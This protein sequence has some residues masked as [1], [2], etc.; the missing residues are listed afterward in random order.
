[1]QNSV[2]KVREA[3]F[4]RMTTAPV[5]PLIVKLAIPT[6]I[7]MLV[8]SIYNMA[9]TFFVAH[10]GQTEAEV[11]AA[12]GAVGVVFSLMAVIQALGFTLGMGSGSIISRALGVK[13][14]KRAETAASS[15]LAAALVLGGLLTVFGLIFIKPLVRFLGATETILP[16]AASYASYILYGAPIMCASFVLNNLL[17]SEGKALFSMV[18]LTLG[19]VLN[20]ALDPLLIFTAGLGISGAAIATIASQTVSFLVMLSFFIFKKSALRLSIRSVSL[21]LRL[22]SEIIRTGLPS[23]L[24]QGLASVANIFLSTQAGLYGGDHAVS[25][26]SIVGKIFMMLF[27]VGLGIGQGYQPVAGYN[28]SSKNYAR[29]KTA[30][31]FTL[32]VNTA[33]MTVFG[34]LAY[35]FAPQV[36]SLIIEDNSPGIVETGALALRFQALAMPLLA[37][38]VS[39]NMTF[40][41]IGR[42]LKAAL[43]STC[44]QGI[45]Y[46]PA[47]YFL[48]SFLGLLGVQCA[49][50]VADVCTFLVS[51][52]F[53]IGFYREISRK[54][55]TLS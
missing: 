37:T 12:S 38:N 28:Y 52:P 34:V 29:V 54:C 51:V 1:M 49:Q 7:S 25:G 24:R 4:V 32:L 53:A 13:D 45:F 40:Q 22:Y 35:I 27:C 15:A 42:K 19:G 14:S 50:C 23:F 11:A 39:C 46:L 44:R 33:V 18:G 30:F 6:V 5:R 43:L 10:I 26:M 41:T 16:Y 17:R 31:T 47:I 8:T 21:S 36:I 20:I 55:R 2:E 3:Q 48:P 9:D